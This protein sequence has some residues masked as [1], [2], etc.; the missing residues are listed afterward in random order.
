MYGQLQPGGFGLV[1]GAY[2]VVR[3][4]G[5]VGELPGGS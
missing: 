2:P 3:R 1:G 4:L 5:M